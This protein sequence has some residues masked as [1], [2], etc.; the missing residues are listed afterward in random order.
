VAELPPILDLTEPLPAPFTGGT[1]ILHRTLVALSQWRPHGWPNEAAYRAALERHLQRHLPHCTVERER[2]V[3][4][5]RRDGIIDIVVDGLVVIGV[6]HG[7]HDACA[8]R[9]IAAMRSY[10]RAWSGKPM[11]LAIFDAPR[12]AV[13]EGPRGASLVALHKE[14]ALVTVR[15][16]T[17]S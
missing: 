13:L 1:T 10:A 2:W 12:A 11:I 5:L 14:L 7:F 3:G 16:P 6:K 8:E 17:H 9:A 15:M 4:R